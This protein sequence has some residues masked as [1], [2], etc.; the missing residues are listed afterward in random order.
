M[1][2]KRRRA[3]GQLLDSIRKRKTDASHER[4]RRIAMV[5]HTL[6]LKECERLARGHRGVPAPV[7]CPMSKV[8]YE[9]NSST[10]RPT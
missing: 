10:A 8:N 2:P 4:E 9:S 6:I 5:C 1:N 7:V 3:P